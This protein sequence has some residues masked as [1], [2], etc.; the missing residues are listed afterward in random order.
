MN[1]KPKRM[2]SPTIKKTKRGGARAGAGRP[3]V[4]ITLARAIERLGVDPATVDPAR[5]LASIAADARTPA[6][7]RVAACRALLDARQNVASAPMAPQNHNL[8][9]TKNHADA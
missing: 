7:A 5:I 2:K 9:W 3:P 6:T 8:I 1:E 4:S